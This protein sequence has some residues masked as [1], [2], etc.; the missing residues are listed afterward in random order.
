MGVALYTDHASDGIFAIVGRKHGPQTGYLWQYELYT[1]QQSVRGRPVRTFGNFSAKKEIEAIAVDNELGYVYY[2]DEGVGIRKYHAHPDSSDTEL[3]LFAR[4]GFTD[5]HEGISIYKSGDS[6]GYILV[7]DQQANKFHIYPR[8]GTSD[9]P[10][11]HPVVKT[12]LLSTHE[13]D[14]SEVTG[15]RLNDTFKHGLFVA[16]SDDGTFQYYSWDDIAGNDLK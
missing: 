5:D 6:T 15:V 16:M 2:S 11:D 3:A 7:S 12:V 8:E 9:N 13:S 1:D 10:H 14:G 4:N